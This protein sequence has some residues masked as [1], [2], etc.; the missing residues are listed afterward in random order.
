V[1]GY[2][3]LANARAMNAA[4]AFNQLLKPRVASSLASFERVDGAQ[5]A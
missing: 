1:G 2:T 4:H 5:A 3:G